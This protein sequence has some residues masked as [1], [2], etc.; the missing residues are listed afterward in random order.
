MFLSPRSFAAFPLPLA[1]CACIVSCATVAQRRV[2]F[3]AFFRRVSP[4]SFPAFFPRVLSRRALS[5][6]SFAAFPLP[7]AGSACLPFAAFPLPLVWLRSVF[8][9]R[10]FT[11]DTLLWHRLPPPFRRP[12]PPVR[13]PS[14]AFRRPFAAFHRGTAAAFAAA[15]GTTGWSSPRQGRAPRSSAPRSPTACH[16]AARDRLLK[17][18]ST[19][20]QRDDQPCLLLLRVVSLDRPGSCIDLH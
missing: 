13:R 9:R 6:R 15:P 11:D 2:P 5:L 14:T 3:A 10:S 18:W 7:A 20:N 12:A 19:R 8:F 16:R 17:R 1:S 4:R